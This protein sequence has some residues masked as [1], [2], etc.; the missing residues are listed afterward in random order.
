MKKLIVLLI[1]LPLF[2]FSCQN[3]KKEPKY[4]DSSLSVEK[5]IVDLMNRMSLYEKACQMNQ[6]VGIE[7][8]KKAEKDL[9]ADDM[10]KSDTQGFYK[11]LFSEDVKQMIT[12]GKIGSFLHVVTAKEANYLQQLAHDSELKIPLLI[13]IDAIHGNALYSGATVYPSPITIASTWDESNS[14]EVGV[15][16][17]FEMRSTG[18]HWAFA[19]NL[20]VMRDARWGRVGETFGEDT[21]LVNQMGSAM[22]NGLQQDDFTGFNKVIACAKHLVAGGDPINGLNFSPMDISERTLNE[23]HLPPFKSAVDQGVF[24]IM[25][26]HNEV[27]GIPS[28]SNKKLMSDLVRDQWGFNGFYVSDWLDIERLETLHRVARDFKQATYLAVDAGIDMHM[29]G[30]NFAESVVE[31]V[32]EGKLSKKR[33][34][35]ACSKILEAK[36]KLGLFENR[37]VDEDIISEKIFTESHTNTALKLARE[38]IVLLKNND[39][40]P[41]K[42]NQSSKIKILVTGPNANNQSI[43]GD[44]HNPQPDENVHTVFEGI[45][46]I[47]SEMG[48]I[49]GYHDSNENIKEISNND[50]NKT[51]KIANQYDLVIVVVGDNSMRYK[52]NQKTAGENTARAELNLAGKQLDLVKRL[53]ETGKE[54]IVVYVNGRPIS[55]PWISENI[56]AIIEAWEPGSFGGLATAEIIFGKINPSGKLPLT[57]PMSVGQLKMFYNHKNS[58]YFRDYA[59]QTN[60]PLYSFGFGLSYTKFQISEPK[61]NGSKFEDGSLSVSVYVKNIGEISGDEIVQLYVSDKFSNVTRPVKELK[62]FKRVSLEAGESKEIIFNLDKSAFAHYDSEMKYIVEAGEFNILVGN[63]STDE[64]LKSTSL[65]IENTVYLEN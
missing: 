44:W 3:Q 38:G 19:P 8:M 59:I 27:N 33:V 49:V 48:Y 47:G 37:Y 41:L 22:I 11:G 56:N 55:E 58:M 10:K 57:I 32:N 5:R 42:K 51:I 16:T 15:Q 18:T 1:C 46:K 21:Y 25:A 2:F 65:I 50:I 53:K 7:H 60:K 35:Y 13:G 40:L 23:I 62:G 39:V 63:S 24:S 28:H 64:D 54:I 26:A 43:L 4:L 45:K 31:L 61:L 30:P 14:Y 34:N 20:D 36:F 12:E 52:W 17:A 29:H 6:F 9:S